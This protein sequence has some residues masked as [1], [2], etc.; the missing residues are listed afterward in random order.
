MIPIIREGA[1]QAYHC[2]IPNYERS[3]MPSFS[4]KA[5]IAGAA[6]IAGAGFATAHAASVS[7]S[8]PPFKGNMGPRMMHDMGSGMMG[9]GAMGTSHDAATMA[10]FQ[11]IHELFVNHDR[12]ERS[13]T[14]L[15]NGIRTTTESDDPHI[16]QLIKDHVAAMGERVAAGNDPGLPVESDALHSIFKNYDK[17]ETKGEATAKGVV[18]IQTSAD[19]EVVAALQQHASEV[20]DFVTQGM[21]AMRAAMMKNMRGMMMGP[22]M[23]RGMAGHDGTAHSQAN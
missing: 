1:K 22:S 9:M 11:T 20:S 13:V 6:I 16:A 7:D 2:Q 10:Q 21:V 8:T 4:W 18:V 23:D 12:I 15:P 19:K 5:A 14:N 3:M 17:V